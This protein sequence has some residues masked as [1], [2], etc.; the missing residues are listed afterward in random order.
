M[1]ERELVERNDLITTA[2]EE[3]LEETGEELKDLFYPDPDLGGFV[4]Q[5][6]SSRVPLV[7]QIVP[8]MKEKESPLLKRKGGM[9][10]RI[11]P[12]FNLD[13][14]DI[15]HWLTGLIGPSFSDIRDSLQGPGDVLKHGMELA[16]IDQ[17]ELAPILN[18]SESEM[19]SY[20]EG[21][22]LIPLDIAEEIV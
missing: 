21:R 9:F 11:A 8:E 10:L 7:L 19:D 5:R 2:I 16:E 22:A 13:E 1:S 20:I 6:F 4:L 3:E 15:Y 14:K 18:I 12:G 17:I